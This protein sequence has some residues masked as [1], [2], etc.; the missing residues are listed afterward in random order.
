MVRGNLLGFVLHVA[1]TAW[2]AAAFYA[3]VSWAAV[4]LEDL[5]MSSMLRQGVMVGG[6]TGAGCCSVL[7]WLHD[8]S[9]AASRNAAATGPSSALR[10]DSPVG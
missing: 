5:G 6:S 9:G 2:V 4:K 10:P 7:G 3:T 8:S 1:Y